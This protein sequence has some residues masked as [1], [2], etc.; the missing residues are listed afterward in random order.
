MLFRS[1]RTGKLLWTAEGG[2]HL[3]CNIAARHSGSPGLDIIGTY[4]GHKPNKGFALKHDG[5]PQAYPYDQLPLNGDRI[6]AHDWDGGDGYNICLN[7]TRI[8]GVGGKV[9]FEMD[10]NDA[11]EGDVVSWGPDALH[12]LWYN[13]DIVGDH[14]EEVLVQMKDGSIRAYLN[15]DTPPARRPCKW[16]NQ[17]YAT[18]LAPGDY[19]RS[20]LVLPKQAFLPDVRPVRRPAALPVPATQPA[21]PLASQLSIASG[22]RCEWARLDD[23]ATLYVDRTFVATSVPPKLKGAWLLR[24]ANDDKTSDPTS[25][26]IGFTAAQDVD[27]HILY[28]NVATTLESKWLTDENGWKPAGFT[29]QSTVAGPEAVRHVRCKRF[30]AGQRIELPGN[31]ST[32]RTSSMYHVV[33]CEPGKE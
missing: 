11:P 15:T 18:L 27:V 8:Y 20:V 4:G 31:G 12:F 19:V 22:K 21:N 7:F 17:A 33:L 5:T 28:T 1:A 24:T 13:V 9:L 16:Q 3:Q 32:S 26:F 6:W 23:G 29:V 25:P 30:T 14:R 2:N 10:L